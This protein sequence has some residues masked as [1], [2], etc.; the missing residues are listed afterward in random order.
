MRAKITPPRTRE[1]KIEKRRDLLITY[2]NGPGKSGATY[3][4][5]YA[6]E[7]DILL[8]GVVEPS[9]AQRRISTEEEKPNAVVVVDDIAGTGKT[10]GEAI[11]KLLVDLGPAM[12]A[13]GI[14]LVVIL[15][16]ATEEAQSKV[17]ARLQAHPQVTTYLHVCNLLSDA[18]RAFPVN[19]IS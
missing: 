12:A 18:N 8:E 14:P 1:N 4:R 13:R 2:L 10:V 16:Y 11:D 19:N 9:K 7:N 5:T 17:Q 15:M 3:A 6:K